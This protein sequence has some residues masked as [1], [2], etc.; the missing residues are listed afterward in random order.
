MK[1]QRGFTLLELVIAMTLTAMLL[2]MLSA[3]LYSVV[4]D[5]QR[6]NTGLDDTLDK[7]LVI[8]QV[9]RALQAAFP[10]SYVDQERLSRHIYFQGTEDSVSFVSAVSPQRQ[11]GL[12]AWQLSDDQDGVMLKLVPAYADSPEER[13]E[14]LE[15][16][17]VL[18]G[19]SLEVRYLVQE[20]VD[21]KEWL[22]EWD[23][24]ERQSLP[25]A[26]H[27]VLTPDDGDDPKAEVL[28]VLAPIRAWR[29]QDIEPVITTLVQ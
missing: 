22:E 5:W 17:N 27:L 24:S 26:V 14:E 8:L 9:D 16:T 3:G 25:L 18:P 2:G 11:G 28:E 12:M 23:G 15:G 13:L 19:Y 21:S 4:N 1:R 6:E 7:S 20:D 10:H 29:S